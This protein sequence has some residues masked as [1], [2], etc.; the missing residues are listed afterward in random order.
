M[1]LFPRIASLHHVCMGSLLLLQVLNVGAGDS[2]P[3]S[4]EHTCPRKFT[5]KQ[6]DQILTDK[7]PIKYDH[8]LTVHYSRCKYGVVIWPNGGPVDSQTPIILDENGN[9]PPIVV[10]YGIRRNVIKEGPTYLKVN[11]PPYPKLALENNISGTVF[12]QVSIN[13]DTSVDKAVIIKVTPSSATAL[14]HGLIEAI[15]EWRFEPL[16]LYGNPV[17]T[18]VIV[19]VDFTIKGQSA[20]LDEPFAVPNDVSV[21]DPVEIKGNP[22]R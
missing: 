17:P 7:L 6:I 1:R 4:N 3:S 16:T 13:P 5:D 12:V 10:K 2:R 22:D 9:L 21:L 11:V 14:A 8:H 20:P 19:P 15:R 18:D